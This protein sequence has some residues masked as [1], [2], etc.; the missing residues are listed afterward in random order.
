RKMAYD[1]IRDLQPVT[2]GTK[3]PNVLAVHPGVAAQSTAELVALAKAKPASLTYGSSGVG[4]LQHLNGEL[5][6]A[7]AGTKIEHVPYKGAAPLIADLIAGQI[8]MGFTSVAAAIGH[9]KGGRLRPIAVTSRERVP[10]IPDVPA[11]AETRS[12]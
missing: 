3:V 8:S 11:L 7:L 1:P 9:I 2:L 4:N 5:F 10:A 12:E 6:N